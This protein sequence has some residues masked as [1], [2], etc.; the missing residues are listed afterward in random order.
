M[1]EFDNAEQ[2][3]KTDVKQIIIQEIKKEI[4]YDVEDFFSLKY[5]RYDHVHFSGEKEKNA[6]QKFKVEK[7]SKY[8]YSI[9]KKIL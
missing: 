1:D 8:R 6:I 2:A 7:K 3:F 4:D 5:V 9:L